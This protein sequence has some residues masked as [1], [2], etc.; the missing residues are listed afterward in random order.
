MEIKLTFGKTIFENVDCWITQCS[1]EK[2]H[3]LED[4]VEFAMEKYGMNHRVT[5]MLG[6]TH[7]TFEA[8]NG[9]IEHHNDDELQYTMFEIY[10]YKD[11]WGQRTLYLTMEGKTP[12]ETRDEIWKAYGLPVPT[13]RR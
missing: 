5:V 12:D 4:W 10:K 13:K 7:K 1:A 2:P 3:T 8:W 11:V 9:T 6:E